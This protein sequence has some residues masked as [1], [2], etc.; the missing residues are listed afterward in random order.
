[1]GPCHL[2]S[3]NG[4]KRSRAS[5][6][7]SFVLESADADKKWPSWQF[8]Y[9]Q[10]QAVASLIRCSLASQH[11]FTNSLVGNVHRMHECAKRLG[12]TVLSRAWFAISA[13]VSGLDG[14]CQFPSLTRSS[15]HFCPGRTC[16][17]FRHNQTAVPLEVWPLRVCS[18]SRGGGGMTEER[19][20]GPAPRRGSPLSRCP[21]S[22]PYIR[23]KPP[24]LPSWLRS[25]T[26]TTC[27]RLSGVLTVPWP[28]AGL[29]GQ[30][31]ARGR[32]P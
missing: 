23:R 13:R 31:P 30:R 28:G 22:S 8:D 18:C 3:R 14:C 4:R 25:S 11:L 1:L 24:C 5:W 7:I 9:Y 20:A 26:A 17:L 2:G 6:L 19:Y 12:R 32:S 10:W 15:R 29:R 27:R 21:S 16:S